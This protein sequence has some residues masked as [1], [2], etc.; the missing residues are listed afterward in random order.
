M[1]H[2][3]SVCVMGIPKNATQFPGASDAQR[4]RFP[5]REFRMKRQTKT[6]AK[7]QN[8]CPMTPTRS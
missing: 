3:E 5:I 8:F 6:A 1:T 7:F 2:V 4:H